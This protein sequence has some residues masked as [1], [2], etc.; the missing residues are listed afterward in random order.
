MKKFMCML[1]LSLAIAS[2]GQAGSLYIPDTV[3]SD[4]QTSNY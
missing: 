4:A 3:Q 2:C 1:T